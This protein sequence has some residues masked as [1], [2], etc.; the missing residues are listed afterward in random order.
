MAEIKRSERVAMRVQEELARMLSREVKD[1]RARNVVV[2][3]V[4]MTDD[5]RHAKIYVR[6]LVDEEGMREEALKGLAKASPMLRSGITKGAKLRYA[7]DLHF[8]YDAAQDDVL[9]IERLLHEVK[10]EREQKK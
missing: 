10:T 5:L 4:S 6:L 8:V 1:P 3:R 9:R 7:P 2:S